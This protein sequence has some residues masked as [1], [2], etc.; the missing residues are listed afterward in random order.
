MSVSCNPETGAYSVRV[1]EPG[2]RAV[3]RFTSGDVTIK[4]VSIGMD[5]KGSEVFVLDRPMV[6]SSG[7]TLEITYPDQIG[8]CSQ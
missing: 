6:L 4:A 1:P 5:D 8:V 2:D 3:I 7:D